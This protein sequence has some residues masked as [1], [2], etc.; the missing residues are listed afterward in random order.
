MENKIVLWTFSLVSIFIF[1][2]WLNDEVSHIITKQ[3]GWSQKYNVDVH[4]IKLS[5]T[6]N[7]DQKDDLW[8]TRYKSTFWKALWM[9]L[10]WNLNSQIIFTK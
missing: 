2:I 7:S 8:M 3:I 1:L 9:S 10:I 5:V 6:K 4:I